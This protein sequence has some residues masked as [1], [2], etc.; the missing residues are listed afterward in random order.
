MMMSGIAQSV[1]AGLGVF[2]LL[3][4]TL[5]RAKPSN[6]PRILLLTGLAGVG[7]VSSGVMALVMS[8]GAAVEVCAA[9]WLT[10]FFLT[11]YF[12]VYA[13]VARSVSVTLLFQLLRCRGGSL[14]VETLV[15]EYAASSR[16]EDRVEVM[17]QIGLLRVTGETVA[18]T[19]KGEAV[20][21]GV[22]VLST[23]TCSDVR[24]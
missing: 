19:P 12:F 3:H 16:F 15:N 9:L 13:G 6:A 5:W 7:L 1:V 4:I 21:R 8:G 2:L 18:L 17:R 23:L 11:V 10:G 22:R 14:D 20:S 24:G